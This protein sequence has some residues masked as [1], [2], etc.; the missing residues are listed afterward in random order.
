M[1]PVEHFKHTVC[2]PILHPRQFGVDE[3]A[4]LPRWK[5]P[6]NA[7]IF[8]AGN[9]R[10]KVLSNHGGF[11]LLKRLSDNEEARCLHCSEA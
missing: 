3:L 5:D 1:S 9:V 2:P 10:N 6:S 8:F 4:L 11:L 7:S